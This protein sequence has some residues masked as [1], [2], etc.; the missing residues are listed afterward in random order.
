MIPGMT[1]LELDWEWYDKHYLKMSKELHVSRQRKNIRHRKNLETHYLKGN[2]VANRV[3]CVEFS[4][5][6]VS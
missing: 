1:R 3:E 6:K 4:L 5:E 2:L